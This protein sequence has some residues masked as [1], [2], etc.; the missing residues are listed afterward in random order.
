M[1][2]PPCVMLRGARLRIELE[3]VPIDDAKLA[4]T[5]SE[6]LTR[7]VLTLERPAREG[8][9]CARLRPER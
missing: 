5:W 7:I 3:A 8:E 1:A 6:G 9:W 4:D 2:E